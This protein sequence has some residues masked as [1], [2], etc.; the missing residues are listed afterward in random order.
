ML[1]KHKYTHYRGVDFLNYKQA[2]N[3]TTTIIRKSKINFFN[4][5]VENNQSPG[6]LWQHLKHIRQ[7]PKQSLP[8]LIEYNNQT[9]YDKTHIANMF[10]EHFIKVSNIIE[11]SEPYKNYLSKLKDTLKDKVKRIRRIEDSGLGLCI[12]G[13]KMYS[14]TVADDMLLMSYSKAGMDG[15]LDICWKY[16]ITWRFFYNPEKCKI[17]VFN[18]R[19]SPLQNRIFTLGP[20]VI[21]ETDNYS[22]LGVMCNQHLS[23]KDSIHKACNAPFRKI[24]NSA[25]S[26]RFALIL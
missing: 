12:Y 3:K 20:N 15:L 9:I 4:K 18:E 10:N 5:A 25:Q 14:P 1:I 21:S 7:T 26:G 16:S 2:R 8:D 23:S 13:L 22:H 19:T 24:S 11:K 6:F 17:V